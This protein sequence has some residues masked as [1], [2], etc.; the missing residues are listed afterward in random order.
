MFEDIPGARIEHFQH[1][2]IHSL[3]IK[4][5]DGKR[6]DVCLNGHIDVVP[7]QD[8][9]QWTPRIDGDLLYGRGAGDMK[10]GI[11]II[12]TLMYELM[13]QWYTKNLMLMLTADE[14]V[15]G[16]HGVWYLVSQ[17]YGAPIVLVPDGGNLHEIVIAE[18]WLLNL[19]L[20]AI[21]KAGHSSRPRNY[22][23]AIEKLTTAYQHIKTTI[24]T[25]ALDNIP[26][27]RWHSVQLTTIQWG[28]AS[29]MIP[30]QA[31][32]TL[33]IR[34]TEAT[35]QETIMTKIDAICAQLW[36]VTATIINAGWV[37][38]SDP[39]HPILQQ[40]LKTTESIL[41]P[42]TFIKEHGASDGR[43]FA[44]QWSIV[45]LQ[46]P[47]CYDIHGSTERTTIGDIEKI[48]QVYRDFLLGLG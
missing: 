43:F 28:Q 33:N 11:A 19:Q 9:H 31:T 44:E 26:D 42:C 27:H 1:E 2:G 37:M 10:D 46:K 13:S 48:Y 5:F 7:P 24:E 39:Q 47:T 23:N 40:Y 21:G 32:G 4:N 8:E 41:W 38:R 22:D 6:A 3:V 17:W 14:E 35:S 15:G 25:P 34:F 18:K 36:W 16:E 30:W 12:T 45:I 29:N 20:T